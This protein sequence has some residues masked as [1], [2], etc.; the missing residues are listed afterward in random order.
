MRPKTLAGME[1]EMEMKMRMKE[2]AAPMA[3]HRKMRTNLKTS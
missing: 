3:E 1:A 2:K